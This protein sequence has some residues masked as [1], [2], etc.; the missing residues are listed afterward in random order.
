MRLASDI[1]AA[2]AF[3]ETHAMIN[4]EL[5]D[6][7]KRL[8]HLQFDIIEPT[9]TQDREAMQLAA[10]EDAAR[11]FTTTQYLIR[12]ELASNLDQMFHNALRVVEVST[13]SPDQSKQYIVK[14][15]IN[16]LDIESNLNI[17]AR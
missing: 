3:S 10:S 16:Q 1:D 6:N 14:S 8:V 4:E 12:N 17:V 5:T 2:R 7:M 11:A 15:A 9:H 13:G